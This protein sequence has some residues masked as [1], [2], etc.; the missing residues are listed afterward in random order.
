VYE[1]DGWSAVV[2]YLVTDTDGEWR[3]VGAVLPARRLRAASGP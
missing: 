3:V 1:D 2:V